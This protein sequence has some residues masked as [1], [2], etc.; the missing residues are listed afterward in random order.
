M[1]APGSS[2][3]GLSEVTTT[4]SER[5]AA[6]RPISG[7]FPRSRFPPQPNTVMRR[8]SASPRSVVSTRSIPSG[9]WA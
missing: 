5:S 8:A 7:R 2:F 6:I 1:I 4:T 3:R 9:V